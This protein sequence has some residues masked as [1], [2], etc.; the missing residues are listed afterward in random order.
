MSIIAL[1]VIFNRSDPP[2]TTNCSRFAHSASSLVLVVA[3][4][5]DVVLALVQVLVLMLLLVLLLVVVLV[6]PLVLVLVL[7]LVLV[8]CVLKNILEN[9]SDDTEVATTLCV[10]GGSTSL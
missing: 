5:M 1:F 2:V 4:L 6:L 10:N 9:R 7:M 8:P 3:L